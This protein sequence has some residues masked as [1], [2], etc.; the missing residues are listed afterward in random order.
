MNPVRSVFFWRVLIIL[1]I[2]LLLAN[3]VSLAAYA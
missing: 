1:I 3:V 2:A